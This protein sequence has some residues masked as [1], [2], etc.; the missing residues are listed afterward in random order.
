VTALVPEGFPAYV[1][2]FHPA[3]RRDGVSQIWDTRTLV[4]W[5]EIA[6]ANGTRVHAG[7]Q[8]GALT[9]SD[10]FQLQG[11][12]GAYDS[13]PLRGTLPTELAV[14]LSAILARHTQTPECCRFA[15]W[16]GY[17]AT[18]AAIRAAPTFQVPSREYHL[19]EGTVSAV[20]ESVFEPPW[21]QSPNL[22]W[23]NDRAWCVATEIDL[24]TT[25]IAC[26]RA[27]RN[28]LLNSPSLEALEIDPAA[29]IAWAT[30]HLN[31]Q[32]RSD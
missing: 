5:S 27:C 15:V 3:Y 31:D 8:L 23:P 11:Q 28:E 17:G 20:A 13:P 22:W 30:D 26:S 12:P 10:R 1:R 6:G 7:M 14:P 32:P 24:N 21:T 2:V 9:G 19:L 29:G 25:Y 16:S 4:R 18:P